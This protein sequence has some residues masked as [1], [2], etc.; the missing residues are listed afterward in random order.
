MR[1]EINELIGDY[2]EGYT[3]Q[4]IVSATAKIDESEDITIFIN[5]DGGCLKTGEAIAD[6]LEKLPNKIITI[7]GETVASSAVRIFLAGDER[8]LGDIPPRFLV[9]QPMITE[10]Y[11]A[12]SDDLRSEAETLDLITNKIA[13]QYQEKTG[14]KKEVLMALLKTES[15]LTPTELFDY[16][17]ITKEPVKNNMKILINTNLKFDE[18]SKMT[19]NSILSKLNIG[20]KATLKVVAN[21]IERT[22]TDTELDFYELEADEPV[23]V[24]ASVRYSDGTAIEDG[25]EF[26]MTDGRILVIEGGAVSE[27][28]EAESEVAN[29]LTDEEQEHVLELEEAVIKQDELNT[30]LE[31]KLTEALEE[32]QEAKKE[33]EEKDLVIA[34]LQK[35]KVAGSKETV[36]NKKPKIETKNNEPKDLMTGV[37]SL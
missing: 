19:I 12:N 16:G 31:S 1:V 13:E 4:D 8:I 33:L 36:V 35:S 26:E 24:G 29:E 15:Y 34:N 20:K 27:I 14:A 6:Y 2:F 37:T 10:M 5:S 23:E 18:M 25:A 22:V 9:H 17:F 21:K 7:A 11:F 3:I 30:E 28:K 32:I